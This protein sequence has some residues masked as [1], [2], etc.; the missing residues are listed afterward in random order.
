MC[1][2]NIA[3]LQFQVCRPGAVVWFQEATYKKGRLKEEPVS[4]T[5]PIPSTAPK[6]A[7]ASPVAPIAKLHPVKSLPFTQQLGFRKE[8]M[9]RVDEYLKVNNLRQR[10]L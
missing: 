3:V 6:G 2:T 7:A 1:C 9:K 5:Q 4:L 8:V 10:D